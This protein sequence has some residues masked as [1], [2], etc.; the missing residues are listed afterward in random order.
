MNDYFSMLCE[1]LDE[2]NVAYVAI[3]DERMARV[4]CS[5]SEFLYTIR[6]WFSGGENDGDPEFFQVNGYVPVKIPEGC[7]PAICEALHRAN[8]RMVHGG[9]QF[10]VDERTVIFHEGQVIDSSISRDTIQALISC[11]V[12][13]LDAY[14]PGIMSIIYAND[15]PKEAM[16]RAEAKHATECDRLSR[17]SEEG[18]GS[19]E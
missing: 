4:T 6:V 17:E 3:D 15:T 2:R 19:D 1:V 16:D 7:V 14:V 12:L 8:N 9:F 11:V 18:D 5:G 10:D 13:M